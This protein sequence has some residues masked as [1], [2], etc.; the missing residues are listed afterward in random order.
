MTRWFWQS[1]ILSDFHVAVIFKLGK[2][3]HR[4]Y[5]FWIEAKE[6]LLYQSI[7]WSENAF[8]CKLFFVLGKWLFL[9]TSSLTNMYHARNIL[10]VLMLTK[11]SAGSHAWDKTF[12]SSSTFCHEPLFP[13]LVRVGR[14][15]QKTF[16]ALLTQP[17]PPRGQSLS[18]E[19]SFYHKWKISIMLNSSFSFLKK[20]TL[21]FISCGK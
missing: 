18:E 21:T 3:E 13:L 1:I 6:I 8:H 17:H 5:I 20:H 14:P 10:F 11:T 7:W 2:K 15:K 16:C 19:T 9:I 4:N 12:F